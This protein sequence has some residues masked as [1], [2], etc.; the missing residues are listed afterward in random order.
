M[1]EKLQQNSFSKLY[2]NQNFKIL[3]GTKISIWKTKSKNS[4]KIYKTFKAL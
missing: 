2:G 3:I 1:N 4:Y